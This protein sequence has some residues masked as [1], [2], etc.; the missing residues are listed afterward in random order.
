MFIDVEKNEKNSRDQ[1]HETIFILFKQAF[2][3]KEG[4]SHNVSPTIN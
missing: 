4:K 3:G 1:F 2:I